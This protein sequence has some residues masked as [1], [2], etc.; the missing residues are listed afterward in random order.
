MFIIG[1][2]ASKTIAEDLS[3]ETGIPL[4]ETEIYRFP[5]NELYVR[6]KQDIQDEEVIVI[7][8]TYPDD[9]IIELLLLL[10]ACKRAKAKRILVIIPYFG[11]AR[12]DRQFKAGEPVS[13]QV[14]ATLFS[15]YATEVINIDPHKDYIKDFFSIPAK[16]VSAVP[17][18]AN[19]LE[20]KDIDVILAPDKG[21][22]DRAKQAAKHLGC[23]FDY[24]EKT[25]IDGSKILMKTKILDVKGLSVVILDDIISTGGTMAAAIKELKKQQATSVY[26]AC[27]HGLFAGNAIEKLKAA[28]CDEIIATDTIHSAY[29]KVKIAPILTS[30]IE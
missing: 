9:H 4:A 30:F 11:Y 5:D 10:D 1:G 6:I 19:Y 29:S 2:S 25:R 27:T 15:V 3:K 26:V 21:A 28:G 8:T 24:L 16:N 20:E 23:E 14:L 12:Q 17:L 18:L 7:Q 22:L 13:A